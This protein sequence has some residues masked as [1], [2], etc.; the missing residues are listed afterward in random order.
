MVEALKGDADLVPK[1]GDGVIMAYELATFLREDVSR[2]ADDARHEQAPCLWSL[3]KNDSGEFIFLVPGHRLNLPPAPE[4][5]E[6]NNP[7]RGLRLYEE[8]DAGLFFGRDKVVEDLVAV[9]KKQPLTMVLG[10]SGTGKSSLVH[11][12]L[13]AYP[14]KIA[15]ASGA[16]DAE[17]AGDAVLYGKDAV[18]EGV[19]H[20]LLMRPA[21]APA[22]PLRELMTRLSKAEAE[23]QIGSPSESVTDETP[24]AAAAAFSA[25]FAAD[26]QR[27][28]LLVIDQFEEL[29]TLCS[30]AVRSAFLDF[31]AD[32]L[33]REPDRLRVV[34]T[35]RSDFEPQFADSALQRHL[36]A[37]K[38]TSE[39]R[40]LAPPLQHHEFREII[41]KPASERV[42]F[43]EPPALVDRLITEV[44]QM[45]GALPLLSFALSELYLKYVERQTA[46]QQR[47]EIIDRAITAEDYRQ[48]GGVVG[49]LSKRA[50]E[51]Y[52]ACDET[53]RRTM[54]RVMLR[55]V[56]TEG[57]LARR[58]VPRDELIYP[59]TEETT[60]PA[61]WSSA[62]RRRGWSSAAAPTAA[63][64]AMLGASTSS[65][66]TMHSSAPGA[67]S[68]SGNGKRSLTSLC[69][70]K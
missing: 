22:T 59:S 15:A 53:H 26:P 70:A 1:N 47:G 12:G 44:I 40:F 27:H 56:A 13:L 29:V 24:A 32:L 5:K 2:R 64:T 39:A 28:L 11:A 54:Q 67:S 46:A 41:E 48:L 52:D 37:G 35:L 19:F 51:E 66:P 34:L 45:P 31:L 68:W 16:A 60:R 6:E 21:D 49:A 3:G 30:N 42:L 43:F 14:R 58:R 63:I 38:E 23:A 10:A 61:R 25:W 69:N 9:V 4:L 36:Q 57:E 50:T 65:R 33:D 55:M 20:R 7:Y 17:V 8:S 62:W 18:A